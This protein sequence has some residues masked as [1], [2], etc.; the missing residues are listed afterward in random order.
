MNKFKI[1][2]HSAILEHQDYDEVLDTCSS[3]GYQSLEVCAWPKGKGTRRYAGVSHVNV[4][5]LDPTYIESIKNKAKQKNIDLAVLG[6]YPNPLDP[7][8]SDRNTYITHIKKVIKFSHL[9]GINRIST[10]IGK[11]KN[12]SID[13]N[14]ELF[15]NVWPDIIAYAESYQVYVGIENCPMY[16]TKDEWPGGLNLASSPYIWR[17]MFE[18]IPSKYFGLSYD[19]SHLSFQGMD[20][21]K[22]LYEFKDRLIHIHLK[23]TYVDHQKL[24]EFGIFSYPLQYMTPKIPGHG[25]INW[26]SFIE[27]LYNIK[28]QHH[29][30]IEIEDK[31][32]ESS[33]DDVIQ[34]LDLSINHIKP[35]L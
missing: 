7:N 21:I 22:P 27:A 26:K 23:D 17:K 31:A 18:L 3:I 19:P 20:Y 9:L 34:A 32:F 14:L 12:L 6:Y 15:K 8:I 4:D 10:F 2:L 30:V 33:H 13:A 5:N 35:F 1:G 29:I 28:Y 11:D 25:D 16:F 24:D